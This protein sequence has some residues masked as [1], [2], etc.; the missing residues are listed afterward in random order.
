MREQGLAKYTNTAIAGMFG[1]ASHYLARNAADALLTGAT[2]PAL[3]ANSNIQWTAS[4]TGLVRMPVESGI[5]RI[6][7]GGGFGVALYL[8]IPAG[9]VAVTVE[10]TMLISV[11]SINSVTPPAF[12]PVTF[13][14][15]IIA[16]GSHVLS[17]DDAGAALFEQL[18]AAVAGAAT[19]MVCHGVE[20]DVTANDTDVNLY[21][22][23]FRA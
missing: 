7:T 14:N 20:I 5:A 1:T 13:T 21:G 6:R 23:G 3:L 11:G 12:T 16:G 8:W 22:V 19:V 4:A 17:S 18:P 15:T 10:T 9:V 2:T